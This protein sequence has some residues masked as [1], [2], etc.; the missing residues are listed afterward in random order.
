MP[1]VETFPMLSTAERDRRWD[2]ARRFIKE[3][4]LS[5]LVVA[6]A[7]GPFRMQPYLAN[8]STG[9]I[10]FPADSPPVWL[11][12]MF[13]AGKKF[14][15]AGRG[16][17]PWIEDTRIVGD[18]LAALAELVA[19]R[20]L[21]GT[22]IGVLGI[23]SSMIPIGG[24]VTYPYGARFAE[25]LAGAE[26][27]DISNEF[28]MAIMP[29]SPEEVELVRH[30]ARACE[31]ATKALIAVAGVG[32][33]E[34]DLYAEVIGAFARAGA[35][36]TEP[37]LLMTVEPEA[38]D[39]LA[40]PHW[41]FPRRQPRRLV[42]GDVIEA[43]MFCWYGGLDSQAQV[44]IT[45]G[46][47]SAEHR[48]L[49]AIARASYEAGVEAIRPG[50]KFDSVW[51][52]M[53][54]VILDAGYWAASPL[55]HTLSPVLNVGELHGGMAEADVAPSLKTPAFIPNFHDP[56]FTI[57]E[58][59]TLAVEPCAALGHKKALMG[60]AVLVTADGAEELNSVTTRMHSV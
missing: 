49:A 19:E 9:T 54:A 25:V 58:G 41:F 59:M 12:G 46:E 17:E 32:T 30:A 15:D 29:R 57:A 52:A 2:L 6:A 38:M 1:T 45:I 24:T 51:Q 28:G 14:S 60:G 16:I 48:R 5:A 31:E 34:S 4:G 44:M 18:P 10:L 53:R 3:Q 23:S 43:E 21:N 37:Q 39:F 8:T 40:G 33:L 36:A 20:G 56:E 11:G 42:E 22:R 47:P 55:L 13:D 27:A 7:E 35:H 26:L 50:A